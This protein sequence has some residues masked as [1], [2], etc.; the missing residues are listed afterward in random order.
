MLLIAAL[1]LGSAR[2]RRLPALRGDWPFVAGAGPAS[3]VF[4]A[5]FGEFF[6][7]TGVL[8]VLWLAPLDEP[9]QLLAAGVGLGAVLLAAPTWSARQPLA[10]GWAAASAVRPVRHRRRRRLRSASAPSPPGST[11]PRCGRRCSAVARGGGLC[12]SPGPACSRRPGGGAGARYR[13]ASQLFDLVIRIGA[14]LVS[15]ARLAAFGLTH[16][17]LGAL[18]WDG[19]TACWLASGAW[20]WSRPSSSSWSATPL[21]FGLEALVAGVQALRLEYYELFSRVFEERGARSVRGTSRPHGPLAPTTGGGAVTAW[22]VG[23]PFL[24]LV[25]GGTHLLLRR[26]GRRLRLCSPSTPRC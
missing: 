19:T 5:L 11:W 6:G 23:L 2:P 10:G 26:R 22:L 7:P 20:R 1:A 24:A 16:A 15:F 18:V 4:G 25:I 12:C 3:T 14:N 9:V 17:A 13:P 8:P 21:T